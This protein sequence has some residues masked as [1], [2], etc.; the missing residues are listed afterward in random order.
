MEFIALAILVLIIAGN[1]NVLEKAGIEGWKALIP[2]YNMYCMAKIVF[3]TGWPFL[4]TFVPFFSAVYYIVWRILLAK[5]FGK[6]I[7]FTIGLV[8]LPFIFVPILGLGDSQYR[9]TI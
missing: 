6:G 1:W 4:I 5:S 2:F 7:G 9:G 3:G 8:I